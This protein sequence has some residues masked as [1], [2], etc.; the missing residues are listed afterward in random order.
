VIW[1]S[2]RGDAPRDLVRAA[3]G[4]GWL[5]TPLDSAAPG[6]PMAFTVAGCA[7]RKL[8]RTNVRSAA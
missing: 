8:G 7:G 2:A 3:A 6:T 1:V 5:V 4:G